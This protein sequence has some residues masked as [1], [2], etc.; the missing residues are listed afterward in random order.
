ML[1]EP[2]R[3]APVRLFCLPH[4]GAGAS[5]Y[6]PWIAP[7]GRAGVAV[8]PVQ[9]PGRENRFTERPHSRLDRLLDALAEQLMPHLDRPFALFGHSM[10]ALVAFGLTRALRAL[11]GPLPV[12]LSVSGRIAP[13]V[14]DS[15]RRL[16]DLPDDEL[17]AE[18]RALGGIPPE[19]VA[20]RELMA[21]Q[22]PLIRADLALNETY[23]HNDE[24]PLPVQIT[25]FGG[26]A[27]P[28]V[29]AAEL[30]AWERQ[31]C[32]AFRMRILP[33][34]HFFVSSA[35][36]RLLPELMADLAVAT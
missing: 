34:G 11:G 24:A 33:G 18:L 6:R 3:S 28:K 10:G 29:D 2:D 23:E 7:L 15:R 21:I 30:Q 5:V 35:L 32:A 27:D 16:H 19:L 25:A 4:A 36:G 22:L 31:T 17:L 12:H 26:D 8:C 9:L 13:D 20:M 1:V 14:R